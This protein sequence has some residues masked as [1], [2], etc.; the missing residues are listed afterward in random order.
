[1]HGLNKSCDVVT[2]CFGA[3][4]AVLGRPGIPGGSGSI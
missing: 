1:M 3:A 2:F 4:Q